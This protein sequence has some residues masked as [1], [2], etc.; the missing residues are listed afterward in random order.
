VQLFASVPI[1]DRD[2]YTFTML[3]SIAPR[4]APP[5]GPTTPLDFEICVVLSDGNSREP[6]EIAPHVS[7]TLPQ[8]YA[9]LRVLV[10]RG[11]L[12]RQSDPESPRR[13]PGAGRYYKA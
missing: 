2:S 9:R 3:T 13:G 6:R 12:I 10:A 5:Q 1:V 11:V 4:E 8:I 7:A